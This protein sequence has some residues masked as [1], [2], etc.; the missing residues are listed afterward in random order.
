[1]VLS[2]LTFGGGLLLGLASSLHCAGMCGP[3]AASLMFGF[4]P[5]QRR[6]L[7]AAQAGR[8]L[9]YVAAGGLAGAA[10]AAFYGAFHHPAAFL[11]VRAAAALSL[12]WIGF[13][14]LGLAPSLAGLDR[15]AAPVAR[16]AAALRAPVAGGALAAGMVWGLLPCGLV[17]GALFYAALSGGPVNG[18]AVMAGFGLGTLPAVTGVAFGLSQFRAL[19]HAP[20]A[21]AAVGLGLMGIAAASLVAPA[22]G[23]AV[24]CL[25]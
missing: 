11:A 8:I 5:N 21:R 1:M 9:V 13:S 18:V 24:F 4:G 7:M 25:P 3:I 12:G 19:A 14:L 10:G 20:R 23:L 2:S 6:A 22:T 15:I 17:Y 16:A